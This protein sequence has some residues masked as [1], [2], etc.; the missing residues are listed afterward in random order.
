MVYTSL[1]LKKT[2]I[3]QYAMNYINARR[4]PQYDLKMTK[5]LG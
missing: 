2:G 4:W 5:R 3:P 1:G